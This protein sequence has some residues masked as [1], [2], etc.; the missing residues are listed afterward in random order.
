MASGPPIETPMCRAVGRGLCD[1][2]GADIAAGAGLVLNDKCTGWVF[3]LQAIGDQACNDV[4]R[5]SWPE[6]NHDTNGLCRPVL[7]RRGSGCHQQRNRDDG[8]I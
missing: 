3:L 8:A 5:R 4:G 1:H 2:I 7:R 6:G